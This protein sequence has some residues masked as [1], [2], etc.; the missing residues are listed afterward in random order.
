M[1][2]LFLNERRQILNKERGQENVFMEDDGIIL[3]DKNVKLE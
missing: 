1:W 2:S 3:V